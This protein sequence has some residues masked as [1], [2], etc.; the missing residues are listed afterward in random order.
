MPNN[1]HDDMETF[2]ALVGLSDG[3]RLFAGGSPSHRASDAEFRSFTYFE[4]KRA[5]EQTVD[6]RHYETPCRPC[7]VIVIKICS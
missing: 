3:E 5:V 2:S 4:L 1:L 7:D 6:C